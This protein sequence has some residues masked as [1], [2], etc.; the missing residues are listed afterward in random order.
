MIFDCDGVLVDS[1]VLVAGIEAELLGEFGVPMTARDVAEAFVGLSDADMHRLIEERW[2]I[3]LPP[4]FA[5]EKVRRIDRSILVELNPVP[6]IGALLESLRGARCVA[7]SS[8]PERIHASLSRTGLARYFEP[9]VFSAS[10]VA[11]GKPAPDLFLYAA[12]VMGARPGHCVVVEDSPHGVA[13]GVSAGMTV[14][15]F[16]AASHCPPDLPDRLIDAGAETVVTNSEELAEA[17]ASW[18]DRR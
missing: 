1:E 13:A 12:D 3:E 2:G 9:H 14:I 11:R 7:S 5:L 17:L 4:E 15:G 6:G 18:I 16:T 8:R 10:M